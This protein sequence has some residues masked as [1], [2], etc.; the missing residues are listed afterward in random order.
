[1]SPAA[2]T[3]EPSNVTT[4]LEGTVGPSKTARLASGRRTS[5]FRTGCVAVSS[6]THSPHRRRR[7]CHV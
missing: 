4:R 7:T 6:A 5:P 1:M 2:A 3:P